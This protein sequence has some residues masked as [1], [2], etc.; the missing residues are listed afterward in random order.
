MERVESGLEFVLSALLVFRMEKRHWPVDAV[1][2]LDHARFSGIAIDLSGFHTL[3][4]RE[5]REWSLTVAYSVAMPGGSL[6]SRNEARVEREAVSE[7]DGTCRWK[8]RHRHLAL[9]WSRRAAVCRIP[10]GVKRT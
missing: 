8:V 9:E 7:A 5:E 6:L 10:V 1:E 4:F 2:L 3:R